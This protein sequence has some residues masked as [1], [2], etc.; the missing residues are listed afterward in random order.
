MALWLVQLHSPQTV[1]VAA[2]VELKNVFYFVLFCLDV[3]H[4]AVNDIR[5]I[6]IQTR[7]LLYVLKHIWRRSLTPS[8][9]PSV[10]SRCREMSKWSGPVKKP[11]IL[12]YFKWDTSKIVILIFLF[13]F[14][15]TLWRSELVNFPDRSGCCTWF[16]QHGSDVWKSVITILLMFWLW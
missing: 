10:T 4:S 16:I 1:Q 8:N 12:I 9:T 15:K 5:H 14:F 3:R 6:V 2:L 7:V 13:F 11:T